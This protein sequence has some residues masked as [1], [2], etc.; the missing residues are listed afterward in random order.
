VSTRFQWFD[1]VTGVL[2]EASRQRPLLVLEDLHWADEASIRLLEFLD[3]DRRAR[4]LAII[5]TYRDSDLDPA[6]PL[7]LHQSELA[8]NGLRS[9][10]ALPVPREVAPHI[11]RPRRT[12][13]E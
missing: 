6:H 13:W 10:R 9:G 4:R 2:A 1:A 3:H 8:R 7:A 5:G 12:P 11:G